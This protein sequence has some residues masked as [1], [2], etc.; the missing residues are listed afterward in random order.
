MALGHLF[1]TNHFDE[2]SK[3][4]TI[5][6]T[7]Q[8]EY[9]FKKIL[10]QS[11]WLDE[12]TKTIALAKVDAI[13]LKIGYPDFILNREK[14]RERYENIEIHPDR[15]FE[16]ILSILRHLT[17]N[18]HAKIGNM[19]DKDAWNTAPAVVNAYYS[20]NKNQIMF[21]AGILQPPFYH[22]HFPRA[23]NY[24]GIG[25]VIGHEITHGFDDKGRL[26]D[27]EGNL[28]TWWSD[29]A[30]DNFREKII[31]IVEQYNNFVVP[32][33]NL[34]LD[35]VMTEG[36][37]I[38]DNGGLKQAFKAYKV[39]LKHNSDYDL[40]DVPLTAKQLFFLNFAQ[41]WCG[42][43]RPEAA[44]SKLKTAVHAPGRFRVLGTLR[45]SKD[46]AETYKCAS[47]SPMNPQKKCSVW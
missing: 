17:K 23:L 10:S 2:K 12:S 27:K 1:V 14:L 18:E 3:N 46:F 33:V 24:G 30:T 34:P 41:V 43:S 38:A 8:L 15:Y 47:G 39:W 45:N 4:D 29:D 36:E 26:F 42:V 32:E 20:R 13:R 21:P 6:M 28:N 25:V 11:E 37:N 19:V 9:A 16:N 22:R 44:R 35:G 40:P 31:C 5:H 7:E